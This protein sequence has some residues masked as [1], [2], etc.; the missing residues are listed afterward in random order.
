MSLTHLKIKLKS[1]SQE[2]R[3]I[4]HEE[5]K[6]KIIYLEEPTG[7]YYAPFNKPVVFPGKEWGLDNLYTRREL[8]NH[9]INVVRKAARHNYLAYGFLRGLK[10]SEIEQASYTRPDYEEILKL[11]LRF[12]T[13]KVDRLV[14]S[15]RFAEW[16]DESIAIRSESVKRKRRRDE[17]RICRMKKHLEEIR[18]LSQEEILARRAERKARY[19][20]KVFS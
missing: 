11:V 3:D 18:S 20:G 2:S 8:H 16:F 1:L 10:Y 15:Q 6:L 12:D 9:R 17:A 14:L 4:R 13:S 5:K 19:T 7:Y